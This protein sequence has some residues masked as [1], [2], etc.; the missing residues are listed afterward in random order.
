VS[1]VFRLGLLSVAAAFALGA[2][3][4]GGGGGNSIDAV[5]GEV[6]IT[7]KDIY[8]DYTTINAEPGP[9]EVTLNEGGSLDHTFTI[10]KVID[11]RVNSK[12][13]R[14]AK[15]SIDLK[16]GDKLTY[17]CTIPGHANMRGTIEVN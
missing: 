17:V 1:R 5:D 11:L 4:G 12:D 2:C 7:A 3:G 10:D 16:A 9:L 8:Y 15:G 13:E 6:T 14:T